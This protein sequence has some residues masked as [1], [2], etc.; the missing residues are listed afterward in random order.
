MTKEE[1]FAKVKDVIAEQMDTDA[2]KLTMET[3]FSKDL[4]ADSLDIFEVIDKLEDEFDI[5]IETDDDM[6]TVGKLVDYISEK[7][8]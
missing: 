5:E 1:T 6:D 2:S 3:S 8:A 4:E 7:A